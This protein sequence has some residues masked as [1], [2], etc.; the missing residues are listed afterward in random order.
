MLNHGLL[1]DVLEKQSGLMGVVIAFS[2]LLFCF[3]VLEGKN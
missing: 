2:V 1:S 3:N